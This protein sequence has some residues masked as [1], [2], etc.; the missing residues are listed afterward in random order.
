MKRHYEF[1]LKA[2]DTE[3]C[4]YQVS[5]VN[6][7]R[8]DE[9]KNNAK[10]LHELIA[11]REETSLTPRQLAEQRAELL[12]ALKGCLKKGRRWHACDSVVVAARA[13]IAKC[14]DKT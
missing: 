1:V 14:E 8:K 5:F 11:V 3:Q 4:G 6:G 13:I 9:A 7:H 10:A 2:W 12:S